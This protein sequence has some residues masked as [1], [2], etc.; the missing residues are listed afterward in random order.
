MVYG[1][2]RPEDRGQPEDRPSQRG[3]HVLGLLPGHRELLHGR[4][5]S[6]QK[7]LGGAEG[8]HGRDARGGDH[9][10]LDLVV[11]QEGE[12]EGHDRR[13]GRGLE[14][15]AQLLD[16]VSHHVPHAPGL[17]LRAGFHDREDLCLPLRRLFQ[18]TEGDA[19]VDGEYSHRVLLV[20]GELLED[21]DQLVVHGVLGD[22]LGDAA[23]DVCGLASHHR[24]VVPAEPAVRLQEVVLLHLAHLGQ[25]RGE[26]AAHGDPRGE[27]V[28]RR[29]AV[30]QR[31]EVALNLLLGHFHREFSEGLGGLLAHGDLL[32][33]AEL[34]ERA[35]ESVSVVGAA[36]PG[37]PR[38]ELLSQRD[39]HF[40]VV[41][42][43]LLQEGQEL[44][45]CPLGAQGGRD[46]A[47]VP[48]RVQSQLQVVMPELVDQHRHGIE[49]RVHAPSDAPMLRRHGRRR[50]RGRRQRVAAAEAPGRG[51]RAVARAPSNH[52]A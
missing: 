11:R 25:R 52:S 16:I 47:Q 8:R 29:E 37:D 20:P 17:V 42:D 22:H 46:G 49:R 12:V 43:D 38:P 4:H 28:V 50:R 21:R 13:D 36:D 6:L 10:H 19:V 51:A 3:P 27:P 26:E 40:V 30:D 45:A 39:E 32:D 23:Q 44:I 24:G 18:L 9:A 33:V 5:E 2:L 14:N 7:L 34:L 35:R 41:V 31:A 15:L 48:D 1:Q